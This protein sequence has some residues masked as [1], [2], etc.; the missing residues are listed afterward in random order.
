MGLPGQSLLDELDRHVVLS[1]LV[2]ERPKQMQSLRVARV[3]GENLPVDLLGLRQ[4]PG[5]LVGDPG[6]Q[7][8]R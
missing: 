7:R 5:L 8:L 1:H 4:A 3:C 6:L 2:G